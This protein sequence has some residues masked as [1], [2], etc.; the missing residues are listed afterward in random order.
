MNYSPIFA[1]DKRHSVRRLDTMTQQRI[2]TCI[3]VRNNNAPWAFAAS[4]AHRS[5][6]QYGLA[7]LP[8]KDL[9]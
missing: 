4:V 1:Y 8:T 9:K 5:A 3:S 2:Q 6:G 7:C